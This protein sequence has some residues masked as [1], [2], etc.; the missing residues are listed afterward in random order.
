[1]SQTL[2][3]LCAPAFAAGLAPEPS[4][5]VSAWADTYRFLSGIASAESRYPIACASRCPD[6]LTTRSIDEAERRHDG[7]AQRRQTPRPR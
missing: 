7:K 1:M 4:L 3:E 2:A 5:E 6:W